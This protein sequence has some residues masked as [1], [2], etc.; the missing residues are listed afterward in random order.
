MKPPSL[1]KI[2]RQ[3]EAYSEWLARYRFP[4][5][6]EELEALARHREVSREFIQFH[7]RCRRESPLNCV[8]HT[9]P[10]YWEARNRAEAAATESNRLFYRRLTAI[11][12]EQESFR[13]DLLRKRD[14]IRNYLLSQQKTK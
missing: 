9:F 13:A 12:K 3:T 14:A 4:A 6:P 5:T 10:G 8:C 1:Q 2:E 11:A 7:N